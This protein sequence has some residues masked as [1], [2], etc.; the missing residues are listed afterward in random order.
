[1]QKKKARFSADLT[2]GSP[3]RLVFRSRALDASESAKQ[4]KNDHEA[5]R[6]TQQPQNDRHNSPSSLFSV[7]VNNARGLCRVPKFFARYAPPKACAAN[8]A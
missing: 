8:D 6:H 5:E 3:V 2:V 7:R 4:R 1:M